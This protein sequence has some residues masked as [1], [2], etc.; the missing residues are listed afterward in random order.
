L[1][2]GIKVNFHLGIVDDGSTNVYVIYHTNPPAYYYTQ[3]L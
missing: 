2:V 3:S 1:S